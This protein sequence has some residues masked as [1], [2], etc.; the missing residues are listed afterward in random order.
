MQFYVWWVSS[1]QK[2]QL[3]VNAGCNYY[4]FFSLM[5]SEIIYLWCDRKI[6][7]WSKRNTLHVSG[8]C[9]CGCGCM[10]CAY[11]NFMFLT[12]FWLPHTSDDIDL[13]KSYVLLCELPET[14]A[15][16]TLY[17]FAPTACDVSLLVHLNA[18]CPECVAYCIVLHIRSVRVPRTHSISSNQLV[19]ILHFT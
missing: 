9:G 18:L 17:V 11:N 2:R 13:W 15:E 1:N 8:G 12:R 3:T 4:C 7:K 5:K 14:A 19:Q 6:W 16:H 10:L